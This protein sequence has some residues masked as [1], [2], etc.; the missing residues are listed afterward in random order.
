[1]SRRMIYSTDNAAT[2]NRFVSGNAVNP[3]VEAV[4]GIYT[5]PMVTS[6]KKPMVT[7]NRLD[8]LLLRMSN[9]LLLIARTMVSCVKL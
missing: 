5:K 6:R 2:I 7:S 3:R 4:N 9:F 8:G 1:M